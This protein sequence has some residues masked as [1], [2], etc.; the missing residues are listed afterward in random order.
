[1]EEP[2]GELRSLPQERKQQCPPA[3]RALSRVGEE[4]LQGAKEAQSHLGIQGT[5]VLQVRLISL[6][7]MLTSNSSQSIN[8]RNLAKQ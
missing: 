5:R 6:T 3:R 2:N 8:K 1:M 7:S 4:S